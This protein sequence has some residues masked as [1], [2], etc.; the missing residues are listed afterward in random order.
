MTYKWLLLI[1][2]AVTAS[3]WIVYGAMHAIN[4]IVYE[5]RL[6]SRRDEQA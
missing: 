1:V 5:A 2:L 4:G 3:L 6:M